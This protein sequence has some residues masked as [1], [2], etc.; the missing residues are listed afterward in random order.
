MEI[1]IICDM[2]GVTGV[3]S[4]EHDAFP[5]A[6]NYAKAR[7]GL[8][9]DLR[10]AI[11]GA[12]EAGASRFTIYDMHFRGD[13][14]HSEELGSD[15]TLIR[16]KPLDNGMR[17]GFAGMFLIGLHA[18][19]GS[20][21]GVLPH[22]YNHEIVSIT[23]NRK[24]V[25]EIGLEAAAAGWHGIPLVFLSADAEGVAEARALLGNVEG[26]ETKC[27]WTGTPGAPERVPF[28]FAPEYA[29]E[30]IRAGARRAVENI[31]SFCPFQAPGPCRLEIVYSDV[32]MAS[33]VAHVTEG[34]V[35]D[36]VVVVIEEDDLWSAYRRFRRTQSRSQ[37]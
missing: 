30:S 25:G 22:T 23:L 28:I 31:R 29:R 10:A 9:G 32:G 33:R 2:E 3:T 15:V 34:K 17:R 12:E 37:K 13:N 4:Y 27:L 7:R 1:Y 5:Q 36:R 6:P 16:G 26:A 21:L 14:I 18:M 24:R 19:A 11:A 8:V 35:R 20:P